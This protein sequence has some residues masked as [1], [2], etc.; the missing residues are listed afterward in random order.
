M[1]EKAVCLTLLCLLW[2]V[3]A[4]SAQTDSLS[5]TGIVFN[6]N[7]KAIESALVRLEQPT[8]QKVW[9]TETKPDGTFRFDRLV[10]GTYKI[11]VHL[12]GYF[13]TSSEVR[14]ESS[15]SVEFTLT[16]AEKVTQ[17]VDVV[18]RPEPINVDSV[19]PQNVVT[20]EVIQNIPY[21]GRQNFL[22]AVAL[23]P[24][25]VRDN[26][27]L[28]HIDGS[29]SDQ[30]RYQL[31]GLYL[32]DSTAGGLGSDIPIDSIESVDLNLANYSA[33]F[34]KS[35]GGVVNVHSQ[36]IGDKYRFNATDF[37][38]GWDFR[39]KSLADFSPRLLFSGPVVQHKLWF[40][41]S[42]TVRYNNSY[43][44]DV[45]SPD[46]RTTQT[47]LDQLVKFQW[48]LKESHVLTMELLQNGAYFSNEGLSTVRPQEATTNFHQRGFTVGVSDR[49]VVA[50]KLFETTVQLTRGHDSDLAKGTQPLQ[51]EPQIWSGNYFEDQRA[52]SKRVRA[53]QTVAWDEKL[54]GLEH[55]FKAGGEF[56]WVDSILQ[57]DRRPF[58]LLDGEGNIQETVMFT[59]ASV[60]DVHNQEYGAFVQDRLII[61]PKLQAEIGLRYDSEKV[62][63]KNNL[64][65][66]AAFS[67]LPFG[68]ARS[69]VSGGVGLFYDNVTLLNLQLPN[70]QRRLTTTYTNGTP[71]AAPSATSVFD[72]PDF[73]NPSTLHWNVEWEH[74]W[75]PRWVSR[76]DYIQKNGSHQIR[77]AA[78][79]NADGFNMVFNNSGSSE[80]R[81]IEF[82][83]DRPIRTN[84]H[85]LGSY[86]YSNAKERPS[87]SI[88]FPDP[89]IESIGQAPVSW[90]SRHR[91]VG[92]GYFPLPT[93]MT[94]S[95]SVETRS[96]FPFTTVDELNRVVG[97]YNGQA[98]PA[99]FV[100]N[101]GIEKEIPIPLAN[102]KR[103]AVRI[104]ATNLFNRF[105]P[106]FVDANVNSPTFMAF[107][108]SSGRHFTARVRILK[109]N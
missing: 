92:W 66:R 106:R 37:I 60:T 36:F 20:N 65:P 58:T 97:G 41:Y 1:Q 49:H 59:G 39:V 35:S 72:S 84:L 79:P 81:A 27:N 30:I 85:I 70:L 14:L 103:V 7:A 45:R 43:L 75:A 16:V 105:N 53:V 48:N 99:Y 13:E 91:F 100:T 56:D 107:S 82:G 90:N 47:S 34:G 32:T 73:R 94:M 63:G 69:K 96:G 50:S 44:N 71:T 109:K 108:D 87:L 95:F 18:A 88:D 22:S 5:L 80:Y 4:L 31:D 40:M 102:G 93:H 101:A 42:A 52:H 19:A 61:N 74:E 38:P 98:M 51:A 15:K 24:G 6:T 55:R 25:V 21:T 64:G 62:T 67:Y 78:Q 26:N 104:G 11:T 28:L 89:A 57:L 29:R 76:I 2:F 68:S 33:E 46:T 86:T 23:M 3:P 9:T 17:E 54:G 8:E 10:F 83:V 77:L 12:R